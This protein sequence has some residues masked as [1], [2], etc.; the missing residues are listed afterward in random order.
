M[1]QALT[2]PVFVI[3]AIFIVALVSIA[4]YGDDK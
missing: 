4:I 3:A 2:D 1:W